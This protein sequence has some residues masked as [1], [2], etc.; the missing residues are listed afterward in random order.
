MLSFRILG[1]AISV[2]CF[3]TTAATAS[4]VVVAMESNGDVVFQGGGTLNISELSFVQSGDGLTAIRPNLPALSFGGAFNI[5]SGISGPDTFG[6]G[7]I[8]TTAVQS[9]DSFGLT[10][11]GGQSGSGPLELLV[12]SGAS[13][14]V[15]VSASMTFSD[16]TFASLGIEEGSYLWSWGSGSN[17]DQFSLLVVPEPT[18][19]VSLALASS[20]IFFRRRRMVPA[21]IVND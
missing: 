13:S 21:R 1:S 11:L 19:L 9:G 5:Y 3:S 18:S 6:T 12:P 15:S 14:T 2:L 7:W 10:Q 20:A 16:H 17:S 8:N 4:V